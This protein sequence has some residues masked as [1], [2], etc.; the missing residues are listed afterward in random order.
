TSAGG[1][2]GSL[3]Y[4]APERIDTGAFSAASDVYSVGV[5]LFELCALRTPFSGK[6]AAHLA[7][8][9]MSREAPLLADVAPSVPAALSALVACCGAGLALAA[10]AGIWALSRPGDAAGS[11]EA[12]CSHGVAADRRTADSKSAPAD[13]KAGALEAGRREGLAFGLASDTAGAAPLPTE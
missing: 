10:S 13:R 3:P 12:V 4:M 6:G 1:I 11:T 8:A 5:I 9:A 7:A 2:T